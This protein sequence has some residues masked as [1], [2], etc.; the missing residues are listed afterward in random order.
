M[1]DSSECFDGEE[2]FAYDDELVDLEHQLKLLMAEAGTCLLAYLFIDIIV[3]CQLLICCTA[4][5]V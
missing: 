1:G 4:E 3:S 5:I 2:V